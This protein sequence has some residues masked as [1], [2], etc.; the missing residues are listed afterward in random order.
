VP[1]VALA[2]GLLIGISLGALGGG[3]SILTVPALVYLLH[4]SPHAATSGSLIVVGVSATAGAVAHSRKAHVRLRQGVV[5]GA[6]GIVGSYIGS[7]WSANIDPDVLLVAF[8][9]L[10][11]AAATAMTLHGAGGRSRR[12]L[13][14][15]AIDS[16]SADG[17][18]GSAG[19][20]SS[21]FALTAVASRPIETEAETE[22]ETK[23]E[24][25]ASPPIASRRPSRF[26]RTTTLVLAATI[27]GLLTGFFGVGGGFVIVP[28][29][30]LVL[31]F[32]MPVAVGTS[33]LVIAINSAVAL[34]SRLASPTHLNWTLLGLFTAAA[35]GGSVAGGRVASRID[36]T[37]LSRAFTVLLVA[38]GVYTAARSLPHVFG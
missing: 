3:G 9:A 32:E 23:T 38:V 37:R 28:A 13:A 34:L 1:A 30:V 12:T 36:A 14:A 26:R 18:D 16:S 5:F 7:R 4:Q 20:R 35:I 19:A 29:L 10:M 17:R 24:A 27:V 31:G 25:R 2:V 21:G 15:P 6:L 33:L 11:L 8:A 22:V